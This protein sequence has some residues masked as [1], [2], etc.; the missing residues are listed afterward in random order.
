MLI[1]LG[2]DDHFWRGQ[3]YT[4]HVLTNPADSTNEALPPPPSVEQPA[5][6]S[7]TGLWIAGGIALTGCV[8]VGIVDPNQTQLLPA[9]AFKAA[10]GRDCPGC[11]M[12]RGL[13]ALLRGDVVRAMNH[14]L[15]L[16]AILVATGVYFG[17][18][19]IARRTG[20][21]QLHFKFRRSTW[22]AIGFAVFAF[23]VVRNLPWTPF[24][25]LG[26]NA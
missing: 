1:T 18:N 20:K 21:R 6:T 23:W 3:T 14:N 5:R 22:F 11:G 13:H 7:R 4:Q 25:W 10:T 9:C 24:E 26:S 8:V 17:W 15:L 2:N 19:A 16:V 12:T